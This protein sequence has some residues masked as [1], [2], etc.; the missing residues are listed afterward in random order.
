MARPKTVQK[1]RKCLFVRMYMINHFPRYIMY[2]ADQVLGTASAHLFGQLGGSR[3]ALA[4]PGTAS[5]G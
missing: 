1:Y 4:G 2:M 5:V 3:R